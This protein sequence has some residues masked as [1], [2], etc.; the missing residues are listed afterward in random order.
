MACGNLFGNS[1]EIAIREHRTD[2]PRHTVWRFRYG[3]RHFTFETLSDAVHAV[4]ARARA[5]GDIVSFLEVEPR[6][7]AGKEEAFR[8]SVLFSNVS[9]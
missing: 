1:V 2:K 7:S 3:K 6:T 8:L 9:K 5:L 4:Y